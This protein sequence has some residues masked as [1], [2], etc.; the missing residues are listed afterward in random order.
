MNI[1]KNIL[2][3]LDTRDETHPALNWAEPLAKQ[4]NAQLTLVDVLPEHPWHVRVAVNDYPQVRETL[5]KEKRERAAKIVDQL[6]TRG[7]EASYVVLEGKTS[8][9]VIR[10]AM[11]SAHDLV[12]RVAK[13]PHS[14]RPGRMGNTSFSLLR[15]CPTAVLVVPAD[16]P[17]RYER[18]LGAVDPVVPDAEHEGLNR[19]ILET[20]SELA[21]LHRAQFSILHAWNIW[22]AELLMPR[23]QHEDFREWDKRPRQWVENAMQKLLAPFDL[24]CD[25]DRV[26]LEM[27]DPVEVIPR[28]VARED[29]DLLVLGAV[30][31]SGL[32]GWVM[33]NTAEIILHHVRCGVLAL[34]PSSFRSPVPD[35]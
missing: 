20:T 25:D 1:F 27:G 4:A 18:I 13:G 21:A 22:G 3:S 11:R 17:P 6:Q 9:E 24:G 28:F 31:R 5:L 30:G 33:G 35:H 14:R 2:V 26:S 34:K 23:H 32:S 29:I 19:Q 12:V 10:Q 15:K 16:V 7:F 8:T